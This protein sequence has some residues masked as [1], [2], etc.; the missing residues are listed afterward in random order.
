MRSENK[1]AIEEPNIFENK[2]V[3]ESESSLFSNTDIDFL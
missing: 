2:I 1:L 3:V